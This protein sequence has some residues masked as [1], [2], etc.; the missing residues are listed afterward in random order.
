[1]SSPGRARRIAGWI[2][3][4]LLALLFLIPVTHSLG[5]LLLS[6]YMGGAIVTHMQ[7]GEPYVSQSVILALIWVWGELLFAIVL[8]TKPEAKTLPVG[9]LSFR[10]QYFTDLGVLF[11]GLVIATGPILL[12]YLIF[13]RRV[14]KGVTLGA[15]R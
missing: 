13:Q 3:T 7:H 12:A 11:A 10:G 4:V 1:M 6:G 2:L 5:V 9:L 14:T 15:F 8:L